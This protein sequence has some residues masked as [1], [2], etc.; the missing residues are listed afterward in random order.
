M[1]P[2]LDLYSSW[3]V[4]RTDAQFPSRKTFRY[5]IL[6]RRRRA[7]REFLAIS[8]ISSTKGDC[9]LSSSKPCI[10]A[11]RAYLTISSS[12]AL[13]IYSSKL[14]ISWSWRQGVSLT[15]WRYNKVLAL[16]SGTICTWGGCLFVTSTLWGICWPLTQLS[17]TYAHTSA[18][19]MQVTDTALRRLGMTIEICA[20]IWL[21]TEPW[22]VDLQAWARVRSVW[23]LNQVA[24]VLW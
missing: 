14:C 21:L 24:R 17:N 12:P 10:W 18:W 5:S 7:T 3:K 20:G 2:R 9:Y 11:E 15:Y 4:E 19:V 1:D 22:W 6:N 16:A 13:S 23:K 8:E